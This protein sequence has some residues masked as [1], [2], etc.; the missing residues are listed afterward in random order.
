MSEIVERNPQNKFTY[1]TI[2]KKMVTLNSD[3]DM[4]DKSI[5][6]NICNFRKEVI[7]T[8]TFSGKTTIK[9]TIDKDLSKKLL[10]IAK[11]SEVKT[12]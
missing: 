1:P 7:Y 4:S 8:E 12:Q 5:E 9:V 2:G 10:K 6:V 3:I 11:K